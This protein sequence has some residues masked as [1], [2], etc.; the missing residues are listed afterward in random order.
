MSDEE[1]NLATAVAELNSHF[2]GCMPNPD[3]SLGGIVETTEAVRSFP[4]EE[5]FD[6]AV[7]QLAGEGLEAVEISEHGIPEVKEAPHVSNRTSKYA[8]KKAAR[9]AREAEARSYDRA[10]AMRRS[11]SPDPSRASFLRKASEG[12]ARIVRSIR[13][14]SELSRP[15]PLAASGSESPDPDATDLPSP[16]GDPRKGFRTTVTRRTDPDRM[17]RRFGI[18]P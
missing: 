16:N 10:K 2:K 11:A 6:S 15:A 3:R 4:T 17:H 14:G 9:A 1:L 8:A 13:D 7:R 18:R 12:A 5:L